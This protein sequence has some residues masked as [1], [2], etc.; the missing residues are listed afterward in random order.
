MPVTVKWS[1]DRT[2]P[3][4]ERM[5]IGVVVPGQTVT[6]SDVLPVAEPRFVIHARYDEDRLEFLTL[7]YDQPTLNRLGWHVAVPPETVGSSTC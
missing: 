5:R 1:H 4:A 3:L 2:T 6:F 7:C